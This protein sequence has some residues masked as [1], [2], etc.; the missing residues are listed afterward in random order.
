MENQ[1]GCKDTT[2]KLIRIN[3]VYAI[4]IPNV[5]TPDG[6]GINDFFF[7][8]GFG[9]VEKHMLIYDRWG[10]L[11]YEGYEM[12]S[13]WDGIYKGHFVQQDV[14]VYK[15]KVKDVFNVW[16]DYTGRVSLIK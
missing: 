15:I 16:H 10:V 6:D 11:F 1:Y 7:S 5:F 13:K 8:T 14:Y 2:D 9:I 12:D 4:Y 3:P